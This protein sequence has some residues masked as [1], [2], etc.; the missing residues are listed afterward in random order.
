MNR[1]CHRSSHGATLK[2][3]RDLSQHYSIVGTEAKLYVPNE[4]QP[5][6]M[7]C[8]PNDPSVRPISNLRY[9][10]PQVHVQQFVW[11]H[12][13]HLLVFSYTLLDQMLDPQSIQ[14]SS[15]L[16]QGELP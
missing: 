7:F 6:L 10:N 11:E 3:Y 1:C 15:L 12:F 9:E 5:A 4:G 8:L 14:P 13:E 2:S 16:W